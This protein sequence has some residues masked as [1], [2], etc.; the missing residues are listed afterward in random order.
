MQPSCSWLGEYLISQ[1]WLQNASWGLA[2][3]QAGGARRQ[4]AAAVCPLL[5]TECSRRDHQRK[6][7]QNG[8]TNHFFNAPR[9]GRAWNASGER[10][11]KAWGFRAGMEAFEKGMNAN[12]GQP[13]AAPRF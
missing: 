1:T 11:L 8:Q 10:P 3:P 9:W 4:R 5:L 2:R 6:Q 12:N 13:P 7:Q